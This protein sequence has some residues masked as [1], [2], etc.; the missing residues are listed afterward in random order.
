MIS[1]AFVTGL[2]GITPSALARSFIHELRQACAELTDRPLLHPAL[3]ERPAVRRRNYKRYLIFYTV[4]GDRIVVI[5]VTHAARDYLGL[6]GG[7]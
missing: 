6:L 3:A 1:A 7:E 4:E 2:R 5:A